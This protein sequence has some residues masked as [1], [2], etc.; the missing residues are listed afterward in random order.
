MDRFPSWV[1]W[2]MIP[3]TAVLTPALGFLTAVVA[4]LILGV[5]R[6]AGLPILLAI[7]TA[8]FS[9]YLLVRTLRVCWRNSALVRT[10]LERESSARLT[11][12]LPGNVI[13]FLAPARLAG[14]PRRRISHE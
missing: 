1:I 12:P 10:V 3:A 11:Q 9:G 7:A 2:L 14:Q 6:D 13:P 8:G 5:L 4:A